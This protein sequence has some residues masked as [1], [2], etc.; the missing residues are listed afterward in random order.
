MNNKLTATEALATIGGLV[1]FFSLWAFVEWVVMQ[2]WGWLLI[3]PA[4]AAIIS[5]MVFAFNQI[6]QGVENARR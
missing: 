3:F 2:P 5:V 6:F 4:L 1:V